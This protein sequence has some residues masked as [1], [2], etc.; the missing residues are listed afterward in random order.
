M[1]ATQPSRKDM[2]EFFRLG[3]L[4]GLCG[5]PFVARWADSIVAAEPS[6]H[7]AFIE[8][9]IAGSQPASTVE[10]LLADVPGQVTPDLPVHML[11][12][13]SSRLISAHAFTPV[14]L[15]LR[16]YRISS[17]ETFPERIYF[18]FVRQEDAI[19]L[20]RDEVYGT[21]PEVAHHITEFLR[22]F[23]PYAPDTSPGS[24]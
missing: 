19:S 12:G 17:L 8:L 10:T 1:T 20:A 13:F 11:L 4:A 24:A 9:C 2:A 5:S 6:P 16:L 14:E 3:L 22:A 23:E 7:I 21:L 15:L 18:E